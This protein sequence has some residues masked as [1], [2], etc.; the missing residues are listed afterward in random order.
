MSS[1]K[2]GTCCNEKTPSTLPS[3]ATTDA[4]CALDISV[5]LVI[6]KPQ[7]SLSRPHPTTMKDAAPNVILRRA[8]LLVHGDRRANVNIIT[9]ILAGDEKVKRDRGEQ[10]QTPPGDPSSAAHP[11]MSFELEPHVPRIG[12]EISLEDL[13]LRERGSARMSLLAA[14][15][16]V[17]PA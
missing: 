9:G 12:R 16:V 11:V 17:V 1:S 10:Q 7:A 14:A 3:F 8:A 5:G 4:S 2:H 13:D 15:D 6:W